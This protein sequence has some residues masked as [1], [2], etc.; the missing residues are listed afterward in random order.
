MNYVKQIADTNRQKRRDAVLSILSANQI[1]YSLYG[2]MQNQHFTENIVVSI[3]PQKKRYVIGAHYDNVDNS[4]GAVDNASGVSVLLN[5][6]L[7]LYKTTDKSIDFVFFDREE[8]EDRGSEAYVN[9]VGKENI[10]AMLN[11]DPCGFGDTIAVHKM[12]DG[13]QTWFDQ[14]LDENHTAGFPVKTVGFTPNGDHMTFSGNG[15]PTVEICTVSRELAECFEKISR[16]AP[17]AGE[18]PQN[19]VP[20]YLIEKFS[21]AYDL[22]TFHNGENDKLETVSEEIMS[23]LEKYLIKA[24][25]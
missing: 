16:F 20:S 4:I 25:G 14:L 22:T 19:S 1:N 5:L 21:S 23:A 8:Y 18:S 13:T 6:L 15:I 10:L 2:Q 7:A 3:N 24:L 12:Y 11:L 9:A 17:T